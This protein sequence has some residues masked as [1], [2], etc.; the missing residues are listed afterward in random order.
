MLAL[1]IAIIGQYLITIV[2]DRGNWHKVTL[3]VSSKDEE[4]NK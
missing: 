2:P 3:G 1:D 4:K